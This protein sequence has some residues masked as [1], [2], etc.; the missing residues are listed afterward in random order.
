M[1]GVAGQKVE[2]GGAIRDEIRAELEA[3]RT[4][5][6]T[7]LE[8][9]SDEEWGQLSGNPAWTVGEV[10]YHMTL[11]PR[12]L[13]EDVR[14][15]RRLG[16]APKLP[17]GLFNALMAL[18]TRLGARNCTPQDVA[19]RYDAAHARMLGVLQTIRDD[20]WSKGMDYPDWDPLLSGYV[21]LER[22]FH[23]PALHFQAHAEEVRQRLAH[24]TSR[25]AG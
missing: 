18:L 13:P 11:A 12:F 7:L 6:H 8:S 4:A 1:T 23:Y 20:E 24:A 10:M 25:R 17:G 2:G 22:L 16:W 3:T 5:F 21:T 14:L 15:I 9:L 19:E